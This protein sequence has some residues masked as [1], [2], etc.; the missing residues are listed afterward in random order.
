MSAPGPGADAPAEPSP[1]ATMLRAVR[2]IA[3]REVREALRRKGFWLLAGLL[4]VGATLAVVVPDL[5][6]DDET[7]TFDIVVVGDADEAAPL[8]EDAGAQLE[9]SVERSTA[10]T[11][12]AAREQV[13][14]GRADLGLVH[15]ID[16][17]IIVRAGEQERLVAATRQALATARVSE[18]LRREGLLPGQIRLLLDQ[19][20]PRVEEV[21]ADSDS[22]RAA[23]LAVS[24]V[25]Y[26]LLLTL[27]VQV[28]N[29][30]A[31][32]KANRVSEVLLAIVRPSSL[33][34]GK[35]VGVGLVGTATLAAA[36]V[37]VG[38]KLARGGDLPDGFGAAVAGGAAWFVLGLALY[39]TLAGALGALVERQEEAGSV[40]TP[41]TA[42]LIGSFIVS[43]S[44]A[45]STLG[46][47]LAYVPFTSPLL[48]PTRIAIGVS[49]PM[50][51]AVSLVLLVVA[52]VVVARVGSTVYAR[53]IVRTG[54][55]L[56]LREV[57]GSA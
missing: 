21:D 38:V 26:L 55:R 27:M 52:I 20:A 15:G 45:D 37:P 17:V 33:L 1:P 31:T 46:T 44:A 49:S 39:L 11:P 24:L 12:A 22:R 5:V 4:F 53:A 3:G 47:V 14:A 35:V 34:V 13:E 8:L 7:T 43:Q 28:A 48:V 10:P 50:E 32:E 30:I 57:L 54:R 41:V 6:S 36:I 25:L 19:P 51:L 40:V 2:L 9:A 42:I 29:G 23:A 18:G 16:P 56:K